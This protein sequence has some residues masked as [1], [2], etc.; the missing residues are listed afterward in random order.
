MPDLTSHATRSV[1][2][3][4]IEDHATTDSSAQ[5]E[6]HEV[7]QAASGTDL[8]LAESRGVGIVLE[9]HRT[10]KPIV[11]QRGHRQAFEELEIRG[12]QDAGPLQV[13]DSRNADTDLV[14]RAAASKLAHT[15]GDRIEAIRTI[16]RR[17]EFQPLDQMIAFDATELDGCTTK[18]HAEPR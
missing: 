6:E 3:F 10:T 12:I 11:Q 14:D 15:L 18:V 5:G 2:R 17:V 7:I 13:D 8:S 9:H 1:E 4:T 16:M